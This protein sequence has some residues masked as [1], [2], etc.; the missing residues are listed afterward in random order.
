MAAGD[1]VK[2]ELEESGV[3]VT[4]LS[5]IL[6]RHEGV[7]TIA[8]AHESV[9]MGRS[10]SNDDYDESDVDV[11]DFPRASRLLHSVVEAEEA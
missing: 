6:C 5:A 7:K 10:Y 1:D 11:P 2:K 4:A 8:F 3:A 9:L